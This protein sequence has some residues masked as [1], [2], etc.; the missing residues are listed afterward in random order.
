[1]LTR[2]KLIVALTVFAASANASS[3]YV[4]NLSQ[5]FGAVDLSSGAFRQIGPKAPELVGGLVPAPNGSLFTLGS[6]GNLYSINPPTGITTLVGPTGLANCAT[7]ASPCG[8]TSANTIGAVGGTIFATDFH[9]N[10]YRVNAG[11][12]AATLIGPTGMQAVP[13]VPF[14]TNPDGSVNLFDST[15]LGV[16]GKLYATFDAFT[17]NPTSGKVVTVVIPAD[18]YQIS[19]STGVATL[20]APTAL[21]LGALADVNGIIYA[22]N[23]GTS[24]VVTFDLMNG[25][26]S[27]VTNFA[28]GPFFGAS[29]VPEPASLAL[30]ILG[31]T[32]VLVSRRRTR[33]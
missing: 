28:G 10:L 33:H 13:F 20:I 17:V 30:S 15:L 25:S 24:Q 14:T 32:A 8:P 3:V 7:P 22:L 31:I 16:G 21:N 2:E 6:S 19:P 23:D 12:G 5:Q 9:N 26:T 4:V 1:M 27:F 29:A 18:L 11:T